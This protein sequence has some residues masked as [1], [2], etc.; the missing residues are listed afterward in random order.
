MKRIDADHWEIPADLPERG[1]AYDVPS[2][3]KD[4]GIRTLSTLDLDRQA[5]SDGATGL[6]RHI[7]GVLRNDGGIE[8]DFTRKR[9]L[10]LGL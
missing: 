8:W 4:F 5:G 9:Q 2:R 6:D 7:S 3:S 10:G 1:M